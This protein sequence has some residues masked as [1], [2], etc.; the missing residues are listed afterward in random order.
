MSTIYITDYITNPDIEKII[1][2][3]LLVEKPSQDVEVLMV[4]HEKIN[5]DYIKQ[6]PKLKGVQRYGVGFDNLDL[7][8]LK[9]NGIVAANNPDYGTEEVSDTAIGM[10]MNISR[11]ISRYDFLC[12]SYTDGSW[13]ENTLPEIKRNS[14]ITVG[15]IG[16]GRIGGSV[17]IK[18]KLLRFKTVIFDPYKERGYEKLLN[19][20]RVDSL[21]EL[22]AISD[23]VSIHTPLN[24]ETKGMVNQKFISQM[25][26]GSSLVNT[27]RGG[28]VSDIEIFYNPLKNGKLNNI[29]LDV[30]PLEPPKDSELIKAWKSR[31]TW[32]EGR[33]IINPHSA[34]FSKEAFIEMRR[35][36]AENALR[37]LN[38]GFVFNLLK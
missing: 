28:I 26:H 24:S 36:A 11:G 16:A 8:L 19:A 32:L 21:D 33:F 6:F 27:A 14:E 15:I 4:W 10:I 25:K 34:Y 12:R 38:R 35:K 31:E 13:Q 9:S 3:E 17:A 18:A 23:I 29:A 5:S 22:L 7:E 20:Q 1:L 2:G 30:L 37:M